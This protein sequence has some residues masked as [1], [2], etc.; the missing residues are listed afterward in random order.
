MKKSPLQRLRQE[1]RASG[2]VSMGARVSFIIAPFHALQH[3]AAD[4]KEEVSVDHLLSTFS[5][6]I[7]TFIFLLS[8]IS[9]L[10]LFVLLSLFFLLF[11]F[12]HY[13]YSYLILS[14][15][16]FLLLFLLLFLFFPLFVFFHY[17]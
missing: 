6:I 5:P 2:S 15:I 10:L 1:G 12:F 8:F 9:F 16:S 14:F 4:R 7:S 13:F 17:F 11:V 3:G